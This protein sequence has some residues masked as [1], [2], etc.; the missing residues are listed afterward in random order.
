MT[1]PDSSTSQIDQF[2]RSSLL[3]GLDKTA[4]RLTDLVAQQAQEQGRSLYLV[5]GVLRDLLLGGRSADLDFV[6]ESDASAF[7]RSLQQRYGGQVAAHRPFGTAKWSLTADAADRLGLPQADLPQHIDLARAR[8]ETYALPA[9]LPKTSPGSILDDMQRRDFS[10]NALALRLS[11]K[12][13]CGQLLDVCGG[14]QDLRNRQIRVLHARSFMDD[15]TRILRALR[16]ALRLNFTI[17][18]QTAD[19]LREALPMLG[20]VSGA[21]LRN[22]LELILAEEQAGEILLRLQGWGALSGMQPGF[23]I[24]SRRADELKRAAQLKSV[25]PA[26]EVDAPA[27]RWCL[28]LAG[29]EEAIARRIAERLSL[30]RRH[31]NCI[32]ATCR[33]LA[34]AEA[35][36]HPERRPSELAPHLEKLPLTALQAGWL[37]LQGAPLA[38]E[39]LRLSRQRWRAIR[40]C[41]SGHDLRALGLLP[42]PHYKRILERLRGAWLDGE[43]QSCAAEQALL[44]QILE[45]EQ[46]AHGNQPSARLL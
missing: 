20:R 34:L 27:V 26:D 37:L 6:I 28:L 21:R 29:E 30:S 2:D 45:S 15:P 25:F 5:G 43:L 22:E 1:P 31:I 36:A 35:L 16:L 40:P 8:Q 38:Q 32:G 4:A 44:Q 13:S 18:A 39:R 17:H 23:H 7:A 10:V 14:M 33:I 9:A 46:S 24:T 42:G 12:A 41:T 19:W 11:P 3:R